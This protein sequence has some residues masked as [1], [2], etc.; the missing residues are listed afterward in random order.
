MNEIFTIYIEADYY[1]DRGG[2]KYRY[3]QGESSWVDSY[4]TDEEAALSEAQKLWDNDSE[5]LFQKITVFG[6]KLNVSG[7]GRNVWDSETD[8]FIKCWQ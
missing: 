4:W 6:R 5:V 3:P 7:S 2:E 1:I 8:R